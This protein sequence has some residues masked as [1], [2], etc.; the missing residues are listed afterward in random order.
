MTERLGDRIRK[1]REAYGMSQAELA[2]RIHVSKNTMNL[3]ETSKTSDPAA[4]KVKAVA[5]VLGV[6]T[7]YLLGRDEAK[8]PRPRKA[9]PVGLGGSFG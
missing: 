3:I 1:A 8:R 9:A 7:D 4:S 5:D 2:R 6:S